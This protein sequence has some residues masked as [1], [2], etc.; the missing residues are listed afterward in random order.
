[1]NGEEGEGEHSGVL[2]TVNV[3]GGSLNDRSV[4][5]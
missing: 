2:K 3:K 4:V 1:M 5:R